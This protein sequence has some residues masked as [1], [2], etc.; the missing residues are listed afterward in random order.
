MNATEII[1]HYVDVWNGRDVA[2][3]VGAFTKDGVY[4]SPDTDPGVNGEALATFVKGLL[5]CFSGP[6]YRTTQSR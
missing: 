6:Y 2:A 4:C 5:G 3:L 1:Q